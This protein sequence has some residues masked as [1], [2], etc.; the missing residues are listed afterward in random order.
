MLTN[1]KYKGDAIYPCFL[2]RLDEEIRRQ[3]R[4][5]F[6]GGNNYGRK[7]YRIS[8]YLGFIMICF[9]C[10]IGIYLVYRKYKKVL[11]EYS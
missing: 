6:D 3:V 4:L 9:D 11:E 5:E 7:N 2:K 10:S 8:S 1:E